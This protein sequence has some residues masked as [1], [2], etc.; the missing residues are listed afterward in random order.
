MS[1]Q[2]EVWDWGRYVLTVRIFKGDEQAREWGIWTGMWRSLADGT[3]I[4]GFLKVVVWGGNGKRA[5]GDDEI[6]EVTEYVA[7][8]RSIPQSISLTITQVDTVE[9]TT[10]GLP[11]T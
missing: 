10:R 1:S 8:L 7:P 3:R 2:V 9:T 5:V 6:K 11:L 4:N